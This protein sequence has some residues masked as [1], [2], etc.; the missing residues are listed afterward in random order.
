MQPGLFTVLVVG[1]SQGAHRIN[2]IAGDAICSLHCKGIGIQVVHVAGKNDE[3]LVKQVYEK[4]GVRHLVFGFL[5]DMGKAYSCADLCIARAGAGTC[6]EISY[7]RIPALLVPLPSA[8]R[9]HQAAN[10]REMAAAGASDVLPESDLT[11]D[12]L[13]D[14]VE[15]CYRDPGKLDGMRQA[16]GRVAVGNA[17]EKLAD[18][19]EDVERS[20]A[21]P[22]A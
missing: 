18:V 19:V 4:A 17:A 20:S 12:R 2:Q 1:G 3:S 13:A 21:T 16:L 14:Y 9:D 10:A 11:V 8:R 15:K 22:G 5:S 7:L 6:A